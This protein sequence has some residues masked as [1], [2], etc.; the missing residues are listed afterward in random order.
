MRPRR[1]CEG[2]GG[3]GFEAQVGDRAAG[4]AGTL[5]RAADDDGAATRAVG[6]MTADRNKLIEARMMA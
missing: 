2:E 1:A 5:T 4:E 3:D 6:R